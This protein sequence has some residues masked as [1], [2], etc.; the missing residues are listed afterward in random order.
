MTSG[1]GPQRI[2]WLRTMVTIRLF[3][4]RVE[5]LY[6]SGTVSGGSH[7]SIGQEAIAA[8][9][10]AAL[11][12][13]DWIITTY[14]GTGHCIAK[15]LELRP[16]MAEVF[17]KVS[18][19]CQGKGG[20]MHLADMAK[21]ILPAS[22]IVGG[23]IP[24]ATGAALQSKLSGTGRV[25]ACFFGDGASNQGV[26][27]EALN[28]ASIWKLPV[29]YVCEN[30][31]YA[32]SMPMASAMAIEHVGE[33]AAAYRLAALTVDGN[34]VEA[35]YAAM[36]EAVERARRGAGPTLLECDTY[37]LRGHFIGDPMHYRSRDE[38]A[39]QRQHDPILRYREQLVGEGVIAEADMQRLELS[40]AAAVD[41][42]VHFAQGSP[43]PALAEL[44]TQIYA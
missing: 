8:G 2:G 20:A 3:E 16:I 40:A 19:C 7:S 33:R 4:E 38:L 22:A 30:N 27:H 39:E 21:G 12:P 23:G 11:K 36:A 17:G 18:G 32:M 31:R 10:C 15:G 29:V 35:V 1:D 24:I 28:L 34:D 5:E 42:A 26:F 14:R 43:A 6:K 9:A 13:D 41:D 44:T 37:R 25:A